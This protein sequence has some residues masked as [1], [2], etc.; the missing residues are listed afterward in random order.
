MREREIADVAFRLIERIDR[1]DLDGL[2]RLMTED[3]SLLV[4]ADH[5][6]S[7][8]EEQCEAWK[9]Y[10]DQCPEYMIHIQEMHVRGELAIIVGSTTGSHLGLP[11][12]EEFRDPLIWTARVRGGAIPEW[13]LHRLTDDNRE[14]FGIS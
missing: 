10:F 12:L 2:L 11:R 13:A 6:M 3:H 9:G 7:G 5:E 1:Q 8:R 4:F 14:R